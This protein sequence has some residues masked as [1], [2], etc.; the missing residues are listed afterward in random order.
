MQ[1]WKF[2]KGMSLRDLRQH[3]ENMQ[4]QPLFS[5]PGS[6]ADAAAA[7]ACGA[8]PPKRPSILKKADPTLLHMQ[9]VRRLAPGHSSRVG[10]HAA[11]VQ[12]GARLVQ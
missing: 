2:P 10:A 8:L 6:L 1:V 7:R 9:Q 4:A 3:M 5:L 12:H 11:G